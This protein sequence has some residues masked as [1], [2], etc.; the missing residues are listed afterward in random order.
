MISIPVSEDMIPEGKEVVGVLLQMTVY[1]ASVKEGLG[2]VE[3]RLSDVTGAVDE[4]TVSWNTIDGTNPW[5]VEAGDP[6]STIL[7]SIDSDNAMIPGTNVWFESTAAFLAAFEDALATDGTLD[8]VL[9]APDAE[10]DWGIGNYITFG[11]DDHLNAEYL[12][13]LIL[14][15]QDVA[16]DV[17]GDANHDGK[18]DGSDVTILADNWQAGVPGGDSNVTWEMGDFNGDH[19]VDGSDVTILADNWQFGVTTSAAAV[20]E[21]G[22]VVLILSALASTLLIRSDNL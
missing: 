20:P 11:S 9:M 14:Q 10:A 17:P 1:R 16:P 4:S 6:S 18:V 3:L 5:D 13:Q 7:S 8:M 22:V 21:P 19:M 15:L 2:D 12:P